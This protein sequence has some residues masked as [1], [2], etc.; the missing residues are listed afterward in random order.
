MNHSKYINTAY[1]EHLLFWKSQ[2]ELSNGKFILT[3]SVVN[4]LSGSETFVHPI[5]PQT[6]S[7][8]KSL[9][10]G[11]EDGI[12][13]V[14]L[15]S[16]Q[17]LLS[18]FS[19]QDTVVVNS[20]M[21][22]ATQDDVEALMFVQ[23]IKAGL[24]IKELLIANQGV[25]VQAGK[26]QN[27]PLGV[28]D[29]TLEND[30]LSNVILAYA[31]LHQITDL[32]QHDLNIKV[33]D[34]GDSFS[35]KLTFNQAVFSKTYIELL[36]KHWERVMEALKQP[37]LRIENISLLSEQESSKLLENALF[38]ADYPQTSIHRFIEEKAVQ[39]SENTA[40]V[41]QKN[42][43]TYQQLNTQANQLAHCLKDK[44]GIKR[45]DFV[46]L[47][48]ERSD[49]MIISM[50]AVLKAGAVYV[51]IDPEYPQERITF[52]LQD[53]SSLLCIS[54]QNASLPENL[55]VLSYDSIKWNDFPATIIQLDVSPEDG[56]YVIYTSGSTGNPKGVL[57]SHRNVV[58]LMTNSKFQFDF[59]EKDVWTVFHSFC[60]DFSVWEMYGALF[61]GGKCIVVPKEITKES[62]KF[63]DLVKQEGVTVL[64]QTPGAFYNFA[65]VLEDKEISNLALR[66]VIFGGEA[67][68]PAKLHSFHT[69]FPEVKLINMYGIT[70][71]T[72]HVTYKEITTV[73][74]ANG[75]SNIGA[76][77][78]TLECLVLDQHL[79]LQV[80]GCAGELFVGGAGLA[81]EYLNLPELTEAR[82]IEHPFRL[83]E[84]L[85]RTGD[86]AKL[87]PSNELEYLGR[88]DFQ[89]KIRGYRI[90]LGEIESQLLKLETVREAVVIAQKDET[91]EDHFL[92]AYIVGDA[93]DSEDKLKSQLAAFL[94]GYMIP[95]YFVPLDKIPLT[96][97]GK[98]N[99]RLLPLNFR[100]SKLETD[101]VAPETDSEKLLAQIWEDILQVSPIGKKHDFFKSGGHSLKATVLISHIRKNWKVEL[102]L[103]EIFRAPILEDLAALINEFEPA[104]KTLT[105]AERKDYYPLSTA[106]Q[107][108]FVLN[109]FETIG[110]T[111]NMPGAIILRGKL[112]AE[113]VKNTLQK[114]VNRHESL[115]T[116]FTFHEGEPVQ[117]ILD[118]AEAEFTYEEKIGSDAAAHFEGFIRTF[119][120]DKAP[121]FRAKLVKFETDAHYLFFDMHHIVSDGVS[122][123]IVSR[124]F[125]NLY[126]NKT[127][128]PLAIQYV[129]YAV[130]QHGEEGLTRQKKQEQYWLSRFENGAPALEIPYDFPRP[131]VQ[132]FEGDL[133]Q[134]KLDSETT[135]ALKNISTEI[136]ATMYM[137]T[138]AVFSIFLSKYANSSEVVI[139]TAVT[140][141]SN[142]ELD[143]CVG[144]FV[145]TL[146]ILSEIDKKQSFQTYLS[147]FKKQL[148][149]DF[150]HQEY[151]FE[152]LVDKLKL[153]RNL[154][155]NP[156]FDIMFTYQNAQ[157]MEE[158]MS[159]LQVGFVP[160]ESKI[161]K[162]D[163]TLHI[164]EHGDELACT[165]EYATNLFTAQTI[166]RMGEHFKHLATEVAQQPESKIEQ[167]NLLT[168]KDLQLIQEVN[169]TYRD[170][171]YSQTVMHLLEGIVQNHPDLTALVYR[172]ERLNYREFYDR[173]CKLAASL[174]Q[175]GIKKGDIVAIISSPSLEM[176]ISMFAILRAGAAFLPIDTNLPAERVSY[177]LE[178][179][180]AAGILSY[181]IEIRHSDKQLALE[182]YN[183]DKPQTEVE[184]PELTPEDLAYLIYTSGSTGQP[185]GVK[186]IHKGLSNVNSWNI[187]KFHFVPGISAT[188]YSGFS[189]DATIIEIFPCI[190]SGGEMHL[191]ESTLRLDLD[192]LV[193]YYTK[194]EI[195][196][197]FLPT[198]IAE[199]IFDYELPYL[200]VMVT[201]GE[202]L[203]RFVPKNYTFYNSYGPTENSVDATFYEVK[204]P[205]LNIPIGKPIENVRIYIREPESENLCGVGIPGELCIAG[206]SLSTGYL[207][208]EEL[209]DEKFVTCPF[210]E[211]NSKMYLT[212]DLCR[213]LPDGNIEFL[214]RIDKQVKIRGY[215]IETGEIEQQLTQLE[216][217]REAVVTARTV[218]NETVLCA[219]IVSDTVDSAQLKSKLRKFL[220]DYMLPSH[221]I[222]VEKIP[223]T[224]N[225]KADTQKLNAISIA[226]NASLSSNFVEASTET[227][228]SIVVIWKDLLEAQK[229]G[230]HDNFFELG[231]NSLLIVKLLKRLNESFP[232]MFQI[233]VLFDQ[234]TI[235]Q[236]AAIV[237]AQE[238]NEEESSQGEENETRII[239]F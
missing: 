134:I 18:R 213:M 141:R 13:V 224:P 86:L 180:K 63:V 214:G 83:G 52:M 62:S 21:K 24:T 202:K 164:S 235:A 175:E 178:D 156:L 125:V 132:S 183:W 137:T 74:I 160:L 221:F 129:D 179:S 102:G 161:S 218:G 124:D 2:L 78:P 14:L 219:Y 55:A 153:P 127:L 130:W 117:A 16:L 212:G 217:I 89:V 186:I 114:L 211:G 42:S 111:Y 44:F 61:Y 38:E 50:L 148:I 98:V 23:E 90:E 149:A 108:L 208:R 67:L 56:A 136:G 147:E 7:F 36:V 100:K 69:Q 227:E 144:F 204:E 96:G 205:H 210:E 151:P 25:Y 17:I 122:M 33:S 203:N 43:Y 80:P 107:R 66:Y 3:D 10:K 110:T 162:F 155:R 170:I 163:L 30:T 1:Q 150:E 8:I 228:K 93:L 15:T 143:Q 106:Q 237:D 31:P 60:F 27:L 131:H 6:G 232:G 94:P 79:N 88:I 231:G 34:E 104:I 229:I 118:D 220:P 123:E 154:S 54:D 195:K 215:R 53:S 194:N 209:T 133:F 77:I 225:G 40:L 169:N 185:K 165:F 189:F 233:S 152:M 26:Y 85:Y 159:E 47:L 201:G 184:F 113:H 105:R 191:I 32:Q 234:P 168:A 73:E 37:D 70:E 9:V 81:K 49:K 126:H 190:T 72:V 193:A 119:E 75:I 173:V 145:N 48:L 176:I 198:K 174:Q 46:S 177:M 121:L 222:P 207:N 182:Q 87:L 236:L 84:K 166:E 11:N 230:I 171:D 71:T 142:S 226:P 92:V 109:Q 120:L 238:V 216:E 19:L 188:K 187:D 51:P 223:L 5:D 58:R 116:Y 91:G 22:K 35:I 167:Y 39:F 206:S 65:Y 146:G 192:Q 28:V 76:P 199:Q 196:N 115:R 59:S 45:G 101:F 4:R 157:L 172:E 181:G 103:A 135:K 82:F 99:R 64:N 20:P 68:H 57:L 128:E 95:D 200:N 29:Q 138:L 197:T 139:G 41:Y 140:G 12:F 239:D 112:D 158:S 97:N